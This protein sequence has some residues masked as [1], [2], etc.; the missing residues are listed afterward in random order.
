MKK[1][2]QNHT[3][4]PLQNLRQDIATLDEKIQKL[5]MERAHLVEKIG[6]HKR[7]DKL[8]FFQPDHEAHILYKLAH[9][10]HNHPHATYLLTLWRQI[11]SA[12]LHLQQP[13]TLYLSAQ[14]QD[15]TSPY[16]T[17]HFGPFVK[18][19]ICD[20]PLAIFKKISKKPGGIAIFTQNIQDPNPQKS[21]VRILS[22]HTPHLQIVTRL[23]FL[24]SPT[25][26]SP[27]IYVVAPYQYR[28]TGHDHSLI[29][30]EDMKPLD[31][32]YPSV[33]RY[34]DPVK[35]THFSLIDMAR[36]VSHTDELHLPTTISAKI[37]GYYPASLHEVKTKEDI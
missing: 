14:D 19:E 34:D 31:I 3:T 30:L 7:Q 23:P 33:F 9:R 27:H 32:D 8:P 20:D 36:Y 6:Q 16:L 2:S 11:I 15:I 24:A 29:W 18:Y 10:Y 13:L 12:S 25:E 5:L 37:L 4:D 22:T 35:N 28:P 1:P 17:E 26:T 21:W